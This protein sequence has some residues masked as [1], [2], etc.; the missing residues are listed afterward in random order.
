MV[1]VIKKS[2]I[3]IVA[4]LEEIFDDATVEEATTKAHNQKMPGESAKFIITDT[5][6]TKAKIK[7][8]GG[9]ENDGSK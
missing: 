5:R 1:K 3:D 8:I 7:L 2:D 4:E 6:F 9:G